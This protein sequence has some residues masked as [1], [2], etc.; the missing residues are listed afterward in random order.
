MNEILSIDTLSPHSR[1]HSSPTISDTIATIKF[2]DHCFTTLA[3]VLVVAI[4]K[5]HVSGKFEWKCSR[6]YRENKY[7]AVKCSSRN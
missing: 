5:A 6:K 7:I 3:V 1:K 2:C 4:L